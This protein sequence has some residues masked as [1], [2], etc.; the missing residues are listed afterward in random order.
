[1]KMINE[2]SRLFLQLFAEAAVGNTGVSAP[3]AGVQGVKTSDDSIAQ[4]SEAPD[5][6]AEFQQLISGPFKDLYD[7]RVQDIVQKRVKNNQKTL[8][9][10]KSM[11]PVLNR[12]AESLGV[13]P[14]DPE[15]LSRAMEARQAAHS[16]QQ[17]RANAMAQYD[18]WV[19]QSEEA[20]QLFPDLQLRQEVQNPRFMQLLDQGL[21]VQDAY[22][23][24]HR[25]RILP[26]VMQYS[27]RKV[28]EKLANRIAANGVRPPETGM[29]TKGS[30]VTQADI[31]HMSRA[32]RQDII[33][34]VQQGEVIRL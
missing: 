3:D 22:L 4:E 34:R 14:N 28:E 17:R 13:P 1:M 12:L 23:V 9:Q 21:H 20:K 26:E 25:D 24:T 18:S 16:P 19:Q 6:N 8:E 32:Q 30:P 27:A 5:R 11:E 33:R 29:T 10:Y 15:A 2:N 7:A 31:S